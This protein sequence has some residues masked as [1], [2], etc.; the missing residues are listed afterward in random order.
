MGN[1][2]IGTIFFIA[3]FLWPQAAHAYIDAGSGAMIIQML[4]G[5]L[6]GLVVALKFYG[7][8]MWSKITGKDKREQDPTP[9]KEHE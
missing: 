8:S 1:R 6:A 7:R 3:I 4:L 5:G 2:K 9:P